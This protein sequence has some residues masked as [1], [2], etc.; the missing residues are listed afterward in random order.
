MGQAAPGHACQQRLALVRQGKERAVH[1]P[2]SEVV[3][4]EVLFA[5]VLRGRHQQVLAPASQLLGEDPDQD[6]EVRVAEEVLVLAR[7]TTN[8]TEPVRPEARLRAA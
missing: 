7:D 4:E 2:G 3:G 5:V 6:A 1:V 8:A